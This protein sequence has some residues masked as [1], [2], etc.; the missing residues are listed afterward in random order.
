MAASIMFH[1]SQSLS[2]NVRVTLSKLIKEL[3][4]PFRSFRD[5]AIGYIR[6]DSKCSWRKTRIFK[7]WKNRLLLISRCS[8]R[9]TSSTA[10]RI[11]WAITS[12]S[13]NLCN[14][15][16]KQKRTNAGIQIIWIFL[17]IVYQK[18][19]ICAKLFKSSL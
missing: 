19:W 6:S 9:N 3:F 15:L 11:S 16:E 5:W 18:W 2:N 4:F 17:R 1:S 8:T 10:S 7:H 13:I 14:C 12:K